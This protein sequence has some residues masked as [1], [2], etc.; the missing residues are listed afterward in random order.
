MNSGDVTVILNLVQ[1]CDR[2]PFPAGAEVA[3]L[4]VLASV[5]L[6]DAMDAVRQH[7]SQQDAKPALPGDI[8]ARCVAKTEADARKA[9]MAIEAAPVTCTPEVRDAALA[10]IRALGERFG[11]L[12]R[13]PRHRRPDAGSPTTDVDAAEFERRRAQA[14]RL[15]ESRSFA[16][17]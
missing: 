9:K 11:D 8:K 6:A 14:L 17:A 16:T 5:D 12:D 15:L 4:M 1:A 3:W 7:Y 2:R 10:Q 13:A